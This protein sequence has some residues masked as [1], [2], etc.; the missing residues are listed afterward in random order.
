MRYY[1]DVE[2]NGFGGP[3][4]SMA[5]VP[6][7]EGL[8]AFYEALD[9]PDPTPWVAEHVIPVLGIA[10]ISRAE[11]AGKLERYLHDVEWPVLVADWPEDIARAAE[12]M[13]VAPGRRIAVRQVRFELCDP[14]AFDAAVASAVPHNAYHDAVALRRHMLDRG[15]D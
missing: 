12:A 4:I 6:E 5:L 2:M 11:F 8:P 9:C 13:I 14:P 7:D 15:C 3:L 1:L 10:P